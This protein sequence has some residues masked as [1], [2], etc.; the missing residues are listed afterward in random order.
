MTLLGLFWFCFEITHT[1]RNELSVGDQK[2]MKIAPYF[3][4]TVGHIRVDVFLNCFNFD[5]S[6]VDNIYVRQF[7][8]RG[9]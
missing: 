1:F 7:P 8:F 2:F 4:G 3:P 5:D 9:Q 6:L